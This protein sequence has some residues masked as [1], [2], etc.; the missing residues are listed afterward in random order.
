[1]NISEIHGEIYYE[2]DPISEQV[3]RRFSQLYFHD[4]SNLFV[5]EGKIICSGVIFEQKF[6]ISVFRFI[7]RNGKL[8]SGYIQNFSEV[9]LDT[10]YYVQDEMLYLVECGLLSEKTEIVS[11]PF[12]SDKIKAESIKYY[13]FP[14][15]NRYPFVLLG[16]ETHMKEIR[17]GE[18]GELFQSSCSQ[19]LSFI[20]SGKSASLSFESGLL[21]CEE[22]VCKWVPYGEKESY[23][24]K[25]LLTGFAFGDP[26]F[27]ITVD[28]KE[29]RKIQFEDG[30]WYPLI[31]PF[32]KK[33]LID[34]PVQL[35]N[36]E[37]TSMCSVCQFRTKSLF[38][39]CKPCNPKLLQS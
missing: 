7:Y 14:Y 9:G 5:G 12:V 31:E 10:K 20:K 6:L 23:S 24:A 8:V 28:K 15:A 25:L 30:K 11:L 33:E 13:S 27:D 26:V 38:G 34:Y 3:L 17:K 37:Q 19:L 1:M 32:M 36:G 29:N 18:S 4:E 39:K 16:L 22:S 35:E 2:L 21:L